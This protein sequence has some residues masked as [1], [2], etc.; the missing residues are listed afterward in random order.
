VFTPEHNDVDQVG[1]SNMTSFTDDSSSQLSLSRET[2]QE[3]QVTRSHFSP[4]CIQFGIPS[5][6]TY[7]VMHHFMWLSVQARPNNMKGYVSIR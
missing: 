2:E 5:Q 6:K 7:L 1:S 3:T 4:L